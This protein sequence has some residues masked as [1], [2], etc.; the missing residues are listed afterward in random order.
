MNNGITYTVR[1]YSSCGDARGQTLI[2]TYWL[3]RQPHCFVSV[4]FWPAAGLNG[5]RRPSV[6]AK[7]SSD[8]AQ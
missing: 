3:S 5:E 6:A 4:R 1:L 7:Q 8:R 2:W